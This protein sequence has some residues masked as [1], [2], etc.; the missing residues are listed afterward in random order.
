MPG[1]ISTMYLIFDFLLCM[2]VI[3]YVL[4]ACIVF[5]VLHFRLYVTKLMCVGVEIARGT[6][7]YNAASLNKGLSWVAYMGC[8]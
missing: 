3:L 1:P 6:L 2:S 4:D 7:M 5:V 8:W